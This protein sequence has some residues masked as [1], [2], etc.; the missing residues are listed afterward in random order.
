MSTP[1]TPGLIERFCVSLTLTTRSL[2]HGGC[3]EN[4][5]SIRTSY[6]TQDSVDC[7]ERV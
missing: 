4:V 6:P 3:D 1:L 5:R 2:G 7:P